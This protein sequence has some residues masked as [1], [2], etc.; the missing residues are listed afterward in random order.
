M[1]LWIVTFTHRHGADSW[2]RFQDQAPT[3]EEEI[4]DLGDTWEGEDRG[5][6]LDITGP[7]EVPKEAT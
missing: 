7:F 1:N 2:P 3:E 6:F 4:S 5:D